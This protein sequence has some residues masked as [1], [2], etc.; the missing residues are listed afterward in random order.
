LRI[1]IGPVAVGA[2]LPLVVIAGPCVI[3]DD[4]ATV[5]LATALRDICAEVGVPFIFKASFDKANRTSLSSYRGP[6]LEEGLAVLARVRTEVGVPVTADIHLPEQAAPVAAVVDLL[7]IPAFLC[8]QTDLL[9]AAGATGRPVNIKKGQFVAP[10]DMGPAVLKVGGPVMVTERGTTFGY[11][12]LVADM[13]AIPR[14]HDLGVPVVF[15]CTHAVQR[16]GAR[17]GSSGGDRELAPVLARAAVAAGA[18]AIFAEVHPDPA[19]A[20][21]DPATQLPLAQFSQLLTSIRDISRAV[22]RIG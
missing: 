12:D 16:P 14:L 4:L 20:L 19:Q 1:D 15:D 11:H 18:D 13:R 5:A 10:A 8:R 2:S 6:G 9:V 3:E 7:Q 21:S 22:G 17:G